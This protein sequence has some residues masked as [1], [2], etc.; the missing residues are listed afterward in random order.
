MGSVMLRIALKL[1]IILWLKKPGFTTASSVCYVF[2][3][4]EAIDPNQTLVYQ[5]LW[6]YQQIYDA[7]VGR[8]VDLQLLLI[9]SGDVELCPGPECGDCLNINPELECLIKQ[10]GLKCF[11][12]NVRGLWSNLC[13]VTELLTAHTDI[14][15]FTLSETHIQDEPDELYVINGYSFIS[16]PRSNGLGGGVAVYISEQIN[17][18]RRYDLESELECIWLEIFPYKTKSF[19]ICSM[20][21]PPDTSSYTHANFKNLFA[22]ML[23]LATANLKEVIVMGDL[24]VNYHRNEDNTEIKSII[25]VNGFKQIVK[26]ATRTTENTATLIDII[27][28]NNPS[29]IACTKVVPIAFSDHDLIGCVR[30][31]HHLK[32]VSKVINCRNTKNYSKELMCDELFKQDWT[33]V[34]ESTDVNYAWTCM[35][36][37]ISSCFDKLAPIIKKRIRGKPSPWLTDEIKKAMNTRDIL[38]RKSRKTKFESDIIAYRKKRNEVNSLLNKAKQA[39][40]KDLLNETSNNL[41]SF[42]SV[43]KKLYPNN[44]SKSSPPMFK[45]GSINTSDPLTISNGFCSYFSTIVTSLKKKVFPLRDCLWIFQVKQSARTNCRFKF[46]TVKFQ[47]VFNQLKSLKK[48]KSTGLDNIPAYVLKD[49]ASVITEPLTHIINSSLITGVFPTDWKLSKLIPIPKSKPYNIIKNYRPISIIPAISKVIEKLVHHQLSSYLE[50]NNLL[51]ESQFGFRKG[52]STELAATL[53]TDNVKRKV[54]EGKLVGAVFL[55][56]TKAFDT[57]N[58]G[59]LLNKLESYG[60]ENIELQWFQDYLFNR[61][62]QVHY[63][64]CI[65]EVGKVTSGVPQGSIIGPLLFVVFFNDFSSC[66]K[67]SNITIYAD[68]TVIYV[69]GKDLFIIETRLSA[70][71][72]S[73]AEW[74]VQNELI[75]NT[76]AGKTESMLFGTAKNLAQNTQTLNVT[77]RDQLIRSTTTYMYL[78]VEINHSLNMNTNF[79]S[80]YKKACGRLRLLRKIRPFLNVKAAKAIYQGMV[81]PILTYCGI[82]NLNLCRT[83]QDKLLSIHRRAVGII[84]SKPNHELRIKSPH[85]C[86]QINS[87]MFRWKRL[88][89][90]YKLF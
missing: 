43:I 12:L 86:N 38:L 60:V 19:L 9:L 45:I 89:E 18:T 64:E 20:Y 11:H 74:C 2:H 82:L 81:L 42:W 22:G 35:K 73:I 41:D 77:Y 25:S 49:C 69:A 85:I 56:L 24:N 31:Q 79:D 6:C 75:L 34:Y 71:M 68:D 16:L 3:G 36:D 23:D 29:V 61:S 90:F 46:E 70:D 62:Q 32:Y 15:I 21:R 50:N 1:L 7:Q 84:A 13:H 87:E 51:H 63:K 52:R 8:K 66:L 54:D 17:W 4:E 57:L 76:N 80:T 55:D 5:S 58:H 48:K 44:P 40:Y 39:Y 33:P 65:S 27:I 78:G 88:F 30:K 47:Q 37:I 10:R 26:E 28:T 14:G 72:K 59:T 83:R 53:F 67:H